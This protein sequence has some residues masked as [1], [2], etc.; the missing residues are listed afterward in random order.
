MTTTFENENLLEE[1]NDY[2]D[3]EDHVLSMKINC[4]CVDNELDNG[5]EFLNLIKLENVMKLFTESYGA[6]IKASSVGIHYN[7]KRRIRHIHFVC[8][9]S[10]FQPSSNNTSTRK[11]FTNKYG[12]F[13]D[14]THPLIYSSKWEISTKFMK[15]KENTCK[16][17]CL[18]YPLK[19][20]HVVRKHMVWKG[21][22]MSYDMVI[23]LQN[24]G[25]KIY[26][27]AI[28]LHERKEMNEERKK[29]ILLNLGAF[30]KLHADEFHDLRSMRL[31]LDEHYIK[32]MKLEDKPCPINFL[33]QCKQ[34]ANDLGIWKYSEQND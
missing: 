15:I 1:I 22:L 14:K 19:E 9:S 31:F 34:V 33:R 21:E 4:P 17:A 6:T 10:T 30:C 29:Q 20:G 18:T 7:G 24:V 16:W 2:I 13:W 5:Y 12:D 26:T 8:I 25:S 32:N 3:E 28:A 11:T 27:E 23:F